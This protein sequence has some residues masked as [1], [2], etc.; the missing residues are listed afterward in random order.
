MILYDHV[1]SS[2]LLYHLLYNSISDIN[3]KVPIKNSDFT[4]SKTRYP[5]N[6]TVKGYFDHK[7]YQ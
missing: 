6:N 2:K 4:I 3:L 7:T 5:F 1:T